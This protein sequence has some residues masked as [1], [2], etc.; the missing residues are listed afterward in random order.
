MGGR[1]DINV[2]STRPHT[3]KISNANKS[4]KTAASKSG[5]P[6]PC[7]DCGQL[8]WRSDYPYKMQSVLSARQRIIFEQCVGKRK[9][10]GKIINTKIKSSRM[11]LLKHQRIMEKIWRAMAVFFFITQLC[12]RLY[13][14]PC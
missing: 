1:S 11:Q 2:V 7:L 12:T 10:S 3:S 4:N 14:I 9:R 8:L 5:S 13:V 6:Q